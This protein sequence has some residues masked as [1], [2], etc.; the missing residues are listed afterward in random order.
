[1]CQCGGRQWQELRRCPRTQSS[2]SEPEDREDKQDPGEPLSVAARLH[3]QMMD[4]AERWGNGPVQQTRV[5][6]RDFIFR[7][8]ELYGHVTSH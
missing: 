6:C 7:C 4:G 3:S 2:A 1:M 5:P 8:A